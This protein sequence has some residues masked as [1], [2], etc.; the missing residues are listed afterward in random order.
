M[1]KV[2]VKKYMVQVYAKLIMAGNATMEK[3]NQDGL[4]YVPEAYH[5]AV[6]EWLAEYEDRN[7][8]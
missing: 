8:E 5:E 7:Y 1:A 3:D 4:R 6:A 2:T